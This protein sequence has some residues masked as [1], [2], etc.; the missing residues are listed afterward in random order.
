MHQSAP[1]WRVC[2]AGPTAAVTRLRQMTAPV[3]MFMTNAIFAVIHNFAFCLQQGTQM[4]VERFLFMK[5]RGFTCSQ[6]DGQGRRC[7]LSKRFAV[8]SSKLAAKCSVTA[9]NG[10]C[11][12]CANIFQVNSSSGCLDAGSGKL[13]FSLYGSVSVGAAIYCRRVTNSRIPQLKP[14]ITTI[15][16]P[17][18]T[19]RRRARFRS[20]LVGRAPET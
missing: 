2:F 6:S 18:K 7:S 1:S 10:R 16:Q 14:A 13:L 8:Q 4:L 17:I 20:R 11:Q 12:R 9:N 3:T 15:R 19:T 5:R